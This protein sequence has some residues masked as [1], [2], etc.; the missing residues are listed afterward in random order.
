MITKQ[1]ENRLKGIERVI[2][3]EEIIAAAIGAIDGKI[4]GSKSK[5]NGALV[6]TPK[7]VV[8]YYK[9]MLGGYQTEDYPLDR[10]SSINFNSGVIAHS[11][12]IHASGNDLKMGWMPK[13]GSAEDF[14]KNVKSLMG[15][16]VEPQLTSQPIDVADQ[17]KKLA[18][19]KDRGI[20]TDD[21]FAAQKQKLL[22][23]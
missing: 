13:D 5:L 7:R 17:I 8:F 14:V 2:P 16:K 18:E 19:L 15:T 9:K 4:L 1:A 11:I 21:E 22:G 6:L 12:K 23:M 20:L 3:D 10:I